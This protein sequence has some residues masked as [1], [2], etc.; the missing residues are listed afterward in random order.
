[1]S[2]IR[3][4]QIISGNDNGGGGNH[5]LNLSFYSKDKFKC[6]IGTIGKGY[7]YE[8]AKKLG[9]DTVEFGSKSAYDGTIL[10]CIKENNIDIINFHGAKAF[11][12][13][14]FLKNKLSIPSTATIH[15]DYKK[16]FINSKFKYLF[17]TPLSIMGVKSFSYY[18]CVSKYIRNL[19]EDDNLNGKKFVVNNGIDLK[20][21]NIIKNRFDLRREYNIDEKSFVYVN[22]ARMHPIK[23][24]LNLVEAFNKVRKDIN[25]VT[26]I[27]VGDGQLEEVIKERVKNLE[28]E[29]Y[30]RFIGFNPNAVDFVNAS[31]VSILT[32]FSEGGSPPLVVLES[33]AVKKPFIS[34][35]VGDIT[36]TINKERGFLVDP[37]SIEDIYLKMKEAYERKEELNNMGENLY[38]FI[39]DKYSMNSFCSEYYNCY[40]EMLLDK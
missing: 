22:V 8:N 25:N 20:N 1:M 23:N 31:E 7:V 26:L 39:K 14:Y 9:I 16:D 4:L 38:N 12:M 2:D 35:K 33:G 34:S 40:K 10:K 36:E 5:V 27:L 3:V 24:H 6:I 21:I 18:I 15:S 17:F 13:H 11:F 28:L 30:V 29:P 32:S 19:L 37:N